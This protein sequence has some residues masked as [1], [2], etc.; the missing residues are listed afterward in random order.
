VPRLDVGLG[1]AVLVRYN[2]A[3][4][5]SP[6]R[7]LLLQKQINGSL[8][9]PPVRLAAGLRHRAHL[10]LQLQSVRTLHFNVVKYLGFEGLRVPAPNGLPGSGDPLLVLGHVLTVKALAPIVAEPLVGEALAVHLQALALGALA[11]QVFH[12]GRPLLSHCQGLVSLNLGLPLE[13]LLS[14]TS[15]LSARS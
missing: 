13:G 8:L 15:S 5:S 12:S 3:S 6:R 7:V 11:S 4:G 14:K 9:R 1:R 2:A 10:L